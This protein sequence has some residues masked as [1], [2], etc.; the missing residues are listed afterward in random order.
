MDL[1]KVKSKP[2]K[3]WRIK[4]RKEIQILKILQSEKKNNNKK[5]EN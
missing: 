1:M 2:I 4:L 5:N 3:H